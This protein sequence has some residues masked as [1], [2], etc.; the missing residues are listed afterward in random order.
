[1]RLKA[2]KCYFTIIE[3]QFLDYVIRKK[4]VKP[5]FKKVDKMVNYPE[6]RNIRKLK[7]I[8]DLFSYY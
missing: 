6:P 3:L 4:E 1:M 5:N 8:L 7:S 2:E